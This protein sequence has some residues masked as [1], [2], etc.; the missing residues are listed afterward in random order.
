MIEPLFCLTMGTATCMR[1]VLCVLCLVTQSCPTLYDPMDCNP[2]GTS[3][4]GDFPG[5][6]TEVSFYALLQGIFPTQGSNSVSLTLQ[7]DSEPPEK[8]ISPNMISN[9]LHC[10]TFRKFFITFKAWSLL[11]FPEIQEFA[12]NS[13]VKAIQI[14]SLNSS[15]DQKEE[16]TLQS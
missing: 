2:P 14:Y 3:V 10:S 9:C 8:P 4:Y 1:A 5:K 13:V 7:V 16:C 11:K 12:T 15:G 6:N